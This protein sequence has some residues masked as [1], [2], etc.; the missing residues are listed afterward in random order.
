MFKYVNTLSIDNKTFAKWDKPFSNN[1][2][3]TATKTIDSV[4]DELGKEAKK[5][6]KAEEK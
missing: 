4:H 6:K 5:A 3:V 2:L 1:P